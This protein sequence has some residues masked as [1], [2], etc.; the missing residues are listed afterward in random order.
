MGVVSL[1]SS[2]GS[3]LGISVSPTILYSYPSINKLATHFGASV[4]SD[5]SEVPAG[6]TEAS[7]SSPLRSLSSVGISE[8]NL[9]DGIA[10]VG[11]SCRYPGSSHSLAEFWEFLLSK[12]DGVLPVRPDRWDITAYL[13]G[14]THAPGKL[15]SPC[16]GLLF[17]VLL[18]IN[19]LF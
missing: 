3:F 8:R 18:Y 10:V 7:T 11:M 17:H 12:R 1:A 13:D 14:D 19:Y 6:S 9:G 5:L 2:L 16:V 15:V 4:V